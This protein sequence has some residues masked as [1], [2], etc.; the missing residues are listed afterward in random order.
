[1][2]VTDISIDSR[3]RDTSKYPYP[4]KYS[5]ELP[6]VYKDVYSIEIHRV[7][8]PQSQY[9]ID[10]HNNKIHYG[11]GGNLTMLEVQPCGGNLQTLCHNLNI[12]LNPQ[13]I[14]FTI[15]KGI[16]TIHN[17]HSEILTLYFGR[18]ESI[19]HIIGFPKDIDI[20]PGE[21]IT[22]EDHVS[23]Q[24]EPYVFL[25]INEYTNMDNIENKSVLYKHIFN[26]QHDTRQI[27]EFA[28]NIGKLFKLD[29][30]ILNYNNVLYNFHGYNH[31]FNIKIKHN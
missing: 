5:L 14:A 20:L 26:K 2:V 24:K 21:S 25:N 22:A 13:Y 7:Y 10:K 18:Q 16:V 4:N 17:N 29:V 23:F 12:N 31:T 1:M 30:S 9:E 19:G 11:Y 28:P 27:K 3:N 15:H 8:I 6:V